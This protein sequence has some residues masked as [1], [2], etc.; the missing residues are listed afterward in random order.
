MGSLPEQSWLALATG[1]LNLKPLTH[2][3]GTTLAHDPA[4]QFAL[5]R[6]RAKVGLSLLHDILPALG[7]LTLS[8][9]GTSALAVAGGLVIH[10]SDLAAAGR[11]LTAIHRLLL[12]SASLSVQGTAHNFTITRRGLPI[13]RV[14]VTETGGKVV[15]T[16]DQSPAQ[17]LAPSSHLSAS[18]R[19]AAARARLA[20]GSRIPLFVDFQGIARLLQGLPSLTGIHDQGIL[21]V[22]GRLDYL[23]VGS[24]PSQ[25]DLRLVLAL[26]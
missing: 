7:P 3:L 20:P 10:P 18:P 24:S 6:L 8:F 19:L 26:R 4:M 23:V 11:V 1:A 16:L 25:G 2:V 13:P 12:R 15:V 9:Q 21:G 17:A 22:L 5:S 14:V